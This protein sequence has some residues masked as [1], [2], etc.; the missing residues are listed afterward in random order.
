MEL[1]GDRLAHQPPRRRD[2]PR[3]LRGLL[4]VLGPGLITGASDD[5]PSG[6]GTYSQVGSQFGFGLL[7]TALF[8]FPLMAAVQELC[9]RIAL[10]TGQ[11]LGASLRR[12]FPGWLVGLAVI[13]LLVANT[14]NVGADLGAVAAG[15]AL[16]SRGALK[17][18]WL[19][20]PV[21]ALILGMQIFAS[22]NTI[23]RIFKWLTLALFAYVISAIY[24]H[25]SLQDVLWA[26]FVPHVE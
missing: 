6:I 15:G 22:Y 25:P 5:D 21:A 23:F 26:T 9:A 18:I 7:W 1:P 11:G 8:T 4:R 20:V 17:A 24:A 16:L 3:G 14:I 13:G 2:R 10:Q 19:V 12:K